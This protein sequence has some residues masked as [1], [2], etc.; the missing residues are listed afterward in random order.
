MQTN[1]EWSTIFQFQTTHSGGIPISVDISSWTMIGTAERT[2]LIDNSLP[3]A[4][5]SRL[6]LGGGI[7]QLIINLSEDDT[8]FLDV[9]K[10]SFEI[11]R[12]DPLPQRPVLKFFIQNYK[13]LTDV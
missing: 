5:G 3:L 13:G 6:S 12:T 9:G 4:M 11:I 1:S 10:I 8:A 7:G 2:N